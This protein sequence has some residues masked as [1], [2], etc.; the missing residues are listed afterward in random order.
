MPGN[1]DDWK[2][3][4]SNGT[5]L[6]EAEIAFI[7]ASYMDKLSIE[8][9]ARKLQCASRTVTKYYGIFRDQGLDKDRKISLRRE[10]PR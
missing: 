1:C 7:K 4:R 3:P 2:K 6:T 5:G 9:V 10:S 8:Y